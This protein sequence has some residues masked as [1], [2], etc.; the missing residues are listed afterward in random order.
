MKTLIYALLCVGAGCLPG[1]ARHEKDPA[2]L[3]YE[4]LVA[5]VRAGRADVVW[6]SLTPKSQA[7]LAQKLGVDAD[8]T[9]EVL[10]KVLGIR[11]G[12]QFE[13]DIPQRAR[14]DEASTTTDTRVIV[15][16][17]AGQQWRL[18]IRKIEDNWRV[19]LFDSQPAPPAE[20]EG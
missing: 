18:K 15:G 5:A 8:A 1:C 4:R 16:P 3:A 10:S 14:L 12:W 2:L 7:L 20:G 17:L 9:P 11:P 19:D 6:T 13:L